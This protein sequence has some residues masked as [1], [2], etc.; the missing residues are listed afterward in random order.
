MV[1]PAGTGA[2]VMILT[3][4][5][6]RQRQDRGLAGADLPDD[7]Q[8]DRGV[9]A[10]A[11]D[12]VG[13]H[14]VAVHRGVVEARQ[15]DRGDHVLG[16]GQAERLHQRLREGRQRGDRG[17]DALDVVGDGQQVSHRCPGRVLLAQDG[18]ARDALGGAGARARRRRPR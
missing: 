5:P 6:G 1:A 17:Q 8:R 14:G 2:P 9:L 12:V 15:R 4:V 18:A 11:G 10:G 16:Q 13:D 7:R 3:A